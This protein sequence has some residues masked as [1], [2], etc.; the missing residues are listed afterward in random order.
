M[1]SYL[2]NITVSHKMENSSSFIL[3]VSLYLLFV[4]PTLTSIAFFVDVLIVFD[5]LCLLFTVQFYF[6]ED[7]GITCFGF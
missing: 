7:Y 5:L 4:A 2:D 3:Q 1:E 6:T